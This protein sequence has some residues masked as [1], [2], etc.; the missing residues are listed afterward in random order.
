[1]CGFRNACCV[2]QGSCCGFGRPCC[3]FPEGPCCGSGG[4]V[5]DAGAW[6]EVGTSCC[7]LWGTRIAGRGQHET[8]DP[9]TEPPNSQKAPRNPQHAP[10]EPHHAP[11]NPQHG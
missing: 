10:P 5:A 11:R 6:R 8:P 2:S 7:G 1:C 3:V 4:E 9:Q